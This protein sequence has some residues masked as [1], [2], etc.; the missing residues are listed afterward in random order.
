ME[1]TAARAAIVKSLNTQLD[2]SHPQPRGWSVQLTSM[3]QTRANPEPRQ[4][5]LLTLG[6]VDV[7]AADRMRQCCQSA[8]RAGDG[9]AA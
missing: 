4:M 1:F 5:M 7:R 3:D 2:Q 9:T 8:P 6:A